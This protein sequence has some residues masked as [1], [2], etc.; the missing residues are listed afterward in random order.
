MQHPTKLP[1]F[2]V[3]DVE[4]SVNNRILDVV[5]GGAPP[6]L[7]TGGDLLTA[8]DA[9][10]LATRGGAQVLGRNDIG[11]LEAGKAADFVAV[12]M[13]RLEYA[14]AQHDPIAALL[15]AAST[16]VDHVYVHGKP[17]VSGGQL[18][19]VDVDEIVM[20]Q[21]RLARSLVD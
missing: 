9:L 4:V 17:V 18:V 21:N 19:T 12:S 6:A 14:G 2:Y 8:R 1:F 20:E 3:D 15:F 7:Y 10:R 5:A 16:R 13:D 11:S